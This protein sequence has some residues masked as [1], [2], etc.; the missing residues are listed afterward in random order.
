MSGVLTFEDLEPRFARFVDADA[1]FA[2]RDEL[3]AAKEKLAQAKHEA[4]EA[5]AAAVA[6]RNPRSRLLMRKTA[7]ERITVQQIIAAW[8]AEPEAAEVAN[9]YADYT[10]ELEAPVLAAEKHL[11][12]VMRK[13]H[14]PLMQAGIDLR[15]DAAER[16]EDAK[17]AKGGGGGDAT[18]PAIAAALADYKFGLELVQIAQRAGVKSPATSF[19]YN[20]PVGALLERQFW[21]RTAPKAHSM[22]EQ[23]FSADWLAEERAR[24]ADAKRAQADA[25]EQAK[26]AAIERRAAVQRVIDEAAAKETA[27]A[28]QVARWKAAQKTQDG[29]GHTR[30]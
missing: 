12:E 19:P 3:N 1:I 16:D 24:L 30:C 26:A 22:P 7:G 20:A 28:E 8:R 13:A 23:V 15:I 25:T 10:W 27:M 9:F 21:K 29:S 17:A 2:A 4:V 5:Q 6:A 11:A 18:T 14:E